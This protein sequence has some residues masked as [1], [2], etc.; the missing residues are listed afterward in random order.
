MEEPHAVSERRLTLPTIWR[1]IGWL[2][3]AAVVITGVAIALNAGELFVAVALLAA[4]VALACVGVI[5]TAIVGLA[6]GRDERGYF[7]TSLVG[8]VFTGAI[9]LFGALVSA[10]IGAGGPIAPWGRPLRIR[11]KMVHPDLRPGEAWAAGPR[12]DVDALSPATREALA[13]LWHH[14]AQKEHAS[15][16]AFS[17]L[18]WLL[19]GLGAPAELLEET[20][21]AGIQEID[22][23]RRCFALAAGYAGAPLTVEPI[24]E[25]LRAPLGV[26]RDPLLAVALESLRD[27]C[28]VEDFNADVAAVA[29]AGASDPAARELAAIIARDER[30]HAAL[31]WAVVAW[32]LEVG[33]ARLRRA[34]LAAAEALPKRGPK[35]YADD[36]AALV[37]AA[38]PAAMIAHGRVPAEQ[39]P[40]IYA[41]RRQLTCDRLAAMVAALADGRPAR[42]VAS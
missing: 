12:P 3:L 15:V 38:D 33:D 21:R 23:A 41:R 26:G 5:V 9:A 40:L 11:G 1:V 16:P 14:D 20:H 7:A 36:E 10:L 39:W 30:E 42:A 8:G 25:L 35:A 28:L 17:R 31:A 2:S 4:L 18:A 19:A 32:C 29:A 13:T 27:G 24:P 37:A 22:H 34:V 6:R